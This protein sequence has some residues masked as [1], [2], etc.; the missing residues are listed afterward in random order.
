MTIQPKLI[1]LSTFLEH[2]PLSG[3]PILGEEVDLTL[4]AE[5]GIRVEWMLGYCQKSHCWYGMLIDLFEALAELGLSPDKVDRFRVDN[6]EV[7]VGY[8]AAELEKVVPWEQVRAH[9]GDV[10]GIEAVEP[11]SPEDVQG[12]PLLSESWEVESRQIAWHLDD[13]GEPRASY[14]ALVIDPASGIRR[15][16]LRGDSLHDAHDL[17]TLILTATVHSEVGTPGRPLEVLV[18]DK[19]LAKALA[20]L[21]QAADIAVR[22]APTPLTDEALDGLAHTL[23][24]GDDTPLFTE[25]NEQTVRAYFRAAHTFFKTQ[26]WTR[27]DG[28]KYVGFCFGEGP[29]HYLSVLGQMGEEFGLSYF[30]NWLH[31]CRFLHNQPTLLDFFEGAGE[32]LAFEA[33]G[34]MEGLTLEPRAA[35][36]PDDIARLKQLGVKPPYQ[37]SYPIVRRFTLEG[38]EPPQRSLSDYRVLMEAL[39]QAVRQRRARTITSIKQTITVDEVSVTLRYPASGDEVL[40]ENPGTYR[41]VISQI[42]PEAQ[43]GTGRIEIDAPGDTRLDAINR[44]LRQELGDA[45][46]LNGVYEDAYLLWD[47]DM[48]RGL[49]MPFLFQL[50]SRSTLEVTFYHDPF[51]LQVFSRMGAAPSDIQVRFVGS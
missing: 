37:G 33:A 24:R 11:P 25:E 36:H 41:L 6:Q 4:E 43:A 45:F 3:D 19:A 17:A 32:T 9:L 29:W 20:A 8:W 48:G 38:M 49:P 35:L 28:D 22:A 26:P 18:A 30:E 47:Y 39:A 5:Q 10:M 1:W 14:A 27:L 21:L 16:N 31:L 15:Y 12:L 7:T 51:P 42:N 50:A 34:S 46:W 44:A 13:L 40:T 23:H 2:C